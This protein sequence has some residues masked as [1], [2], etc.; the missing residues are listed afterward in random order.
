MPDLSKIKLNGAAYNLKDAEAR[1]DISSLQ[2]AIQ[3]INSGN[4]NSFETEWIDVY[5]EWQGG[6]Y[7]DPDNNYAYTQIPSTEMAWNTTSL[8]TA[9]SCTPYS[10][11][12]PVI[13]G[14][15][16]RYGNLPIHFD[17][18]NAEVPGIIIFNSS[19][20]RIASYTRVFDDPNYT[21]F[22]IPTGGVWMA[23]VYANSQTY[24][25]QKLAIKTHFE[26]EI[27][28]M[29]EADYRAYF[30]TT[31]PTPKTLTKAYFCFGT[32]DIRPGETKALH[33]LYTNNNIP[34][35]MAAIPGGVKQCVIDD[36][37][38][39][40]LDYMRLCVQN[41]G[42]IICH[43]G[44]D[45]VLT[46]LNKND[47]ET[48]Y[49][50]FCKYK[51]ELEF[52]GFKVRGMFKAGGTG[53]IFEPDPAIDAWITHYYE[54]GDS[55]TGIFPYNF[56][57]TILEQWETYEGLPGRIQSIVENK[58]FG[59]FTVHIY[60]QSVETA[61][62]TILEVLEGY[63]EGVDYEFVTPSQL[64][65]L[66]KPDAATVPSGG[67]AS[68]TYS[69]SMSSNTIILTGSNG[70]T[71]RVTLPV[72][73]GTIIDP[74][75]GG[76]T[77]T[78]S[79]IPLNEQLV[80]FT[81]L[82]TGLIDDETGE[83]VENQWNCRTDFIEIDPTMT[84]SYTA[85]HWYYINFYDASETFISSLYIH[86]D[87]DTIDGDYGSGTLTPAKIPSNTKYVRMCSNPATGIT[88]SQLSLIRI[89]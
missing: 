26:N 84:F 10:N 30:L 69:L 70:T 60:D 51:E 42:E 46:E 21:E 5:S 32:D 52:Y 56:D 41:G 80:N 15:Q 50:L 77:P 59:I 12:I 82:E 22:T 37:Y 86:N 67:G 27:T 11:L 17:S 4:N 34:Y 72:Y 61:I 6:Y 18:K 2:T 33:E 38:K 29:I 16:Y 1:T 8:Y 68:I 63:E 79:G 53:A 87:Y 19:K 71:S 36:P 49:R 85:Y 3:N 76:D 44:D 47:F 48:K 62:N 64:Y 81:T 35:Y 54:F 9:V 58:S 75:S 78:P 55:Y 74:D 45:D 57:R 13:A 65:N 7:Y 25:L 66:M 31:P 88:S 89:A 20:E 73:S 14:E 40:N 39:T 24:T 83:E 23:V 28:D 43:G